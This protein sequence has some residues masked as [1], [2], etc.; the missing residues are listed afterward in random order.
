[1]ANVENLELDQPRHD[2]MSD[3]EEANN[4]EDHHKDLE[5]RLHSAFLGLGIRSIAGELSTQAL[6][7]NDFP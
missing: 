4:I 7:G 1:L 2:E 5:K 3:N 6:K